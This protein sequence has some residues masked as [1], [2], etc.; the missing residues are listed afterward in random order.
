MRLHSINE[1]S[2]AMKKNAIPAI[3]FAALAAFC[4]S[5]QAQQADAKE[6]YG[7]LAADAISTAV[8]LSLPG[9]VE[10][11]P[12]GWAALPLR[13]LAIEHAKTLPRE[14]A[15]PILDGTKAAGWGAAAN[16]L[17]VL[18]GAGPAAPLVGLAVG[19][20]IWKSGEDERNFWQACAVHRADNPNLKCEFKTLAMKA[21]VAERQAQ[22]ELA[23]A[24]APVLEATHV[25]QAATTQN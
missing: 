14:Q 3:A 8:G 24:A 25:A 7:G 19:I 20:A 6:A 23:P 2:A 12:L 16:N 1:W 18:A 5:T 13:I 22:L 10:M 4:G 21:P 15:Q 17:L 9:V 11:N